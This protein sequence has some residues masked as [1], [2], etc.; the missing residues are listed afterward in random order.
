MLKRLTEYLDRNSIKYVQIT[1]SPA[2]TA[3]EIAATAHMSGKTMAKSVIAKAEGKM[4][5]LVLPAASMVDFG[6]LRKAMNVTDVRL[7]TEAEFK[8][9]FSDCE[10][11]AMPPFGNLF[12]LEIIVDRGLTGTHDIAFNA[13]NHKELIRMAYP[14]F[15]RLV[16][17]RILSFG[18]LRMPQEDEVDVMP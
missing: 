3:S 15:E 4:A 7:A 11:G 8:E 9:I 1:H 16:K 17:P 2:Y 6:V 10:I 5:V 13:G 12:G 18:I 14:D